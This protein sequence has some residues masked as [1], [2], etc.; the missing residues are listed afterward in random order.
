VTEEAPFVTLLS[1][2]S[3]MDFPAV[4]SIRDGSPPFVT[5]PVVTFQFAFLTFHFAIF[6]VNNSA[7]PGGLSRRAGTRQSSALSSIFH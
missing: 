5:D 2:A 6:V 7:P 4:F 3:R 1:G